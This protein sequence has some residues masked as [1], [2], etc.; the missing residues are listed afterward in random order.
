MG[1]SYLSQYV[2]LLAIKFNFKGF[3]V[4]IQHKYIKHPTSLL[5]LIEDVLLSNSSNCSILSVNIFHIWEDECLDSFLCFI[6]VDFTVR[7]MLMFLCMWI[8]EIFPRAF[9]LNRNYC[10]I[11]KFILI[12]AKYCL[13]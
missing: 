11:G 13:S 12:F 7:N 1:L 3:S 6:T 2:F 5:M 8:G 4:C 10:I 9:I